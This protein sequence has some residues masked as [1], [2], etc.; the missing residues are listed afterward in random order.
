VKGD[1]RSRYELSLEAA[2]TTDEQEAG[3]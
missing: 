3:F 2:T 1:A